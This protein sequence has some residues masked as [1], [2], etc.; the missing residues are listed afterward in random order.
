MLHGLRKTAAR[1][2]ADA[3]C[4][5]EEIKAITGHV[6]TQMVSKYTKTAEKKKRASAAI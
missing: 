1:K 2:L 3:G 5:E 6:T 4:T